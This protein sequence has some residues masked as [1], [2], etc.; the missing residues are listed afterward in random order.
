MSSPDA[1][2]S[3]DDQLQMGHCCPAPLGMMQPGHC[4]WVPEALT[5]PEDKNMK[6]TGNQVVNSMTRRG[7]P[8]TEAHIRRPMNAFMV[9]AKDERKRL[10]LQY[11]DVQNAE[12]S[13]M[14][15]RS[16]K[17]LSLAEKRPFVEEAEK[18]RVQH[19]QDHPNYKYRPRKRKQVKRTNQSEAESLQSLLDAQDGSM[20]C[21][22]SLRMGYFETQ[23]YQQQ[24]M[25]QYRHY[26]S[27]DANINGYPSFSAD[28]YCSL[29]IGESN[30]A[31]LASYL[32][33]DYQMMPTAHQPGFSA[34]HESHLSSINQ[35]NNQ[36]TG[37][38]GHLNF[39]QSVSE[40]Q[41]SPN[42]PA[43]RT[44]D[45]S[46]GWAPE[47][48]QFS[49]LSDYHTVENMNQ[50]QQA[51]LLGDL[52]WTELEQ[53]LYSLSGSDQEAAFP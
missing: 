23:G 30:S 50:I 7:S 19:V 17:A 44:S 5:S 47:E 9:W 48:G 8:K 11:P 31:F 3:S 27:L 34:Q 38:M 39:V 16:W 41:T 25:S 1:G 10:A 26:Q 32:Q 40:S 35:G 6:S 12:L 24:H 20:G 51:E 46:Y 28:A 36:Q 43:H 2:Y 37:Q 4:Q 14:L 22:E 52:E 13:K 15:G 29:D 42:M 49:A 53:Y 45:T 33:G 18:I 21:L